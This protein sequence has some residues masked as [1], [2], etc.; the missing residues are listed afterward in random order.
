MH[1]ILVVPITCQSTPCQI[2]E[3]PV[4][5]LWMDT[6]ANAYLHT[7]FNCLSYDVYLTKLQLLDD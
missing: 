6:T 5:K 4:Y 7:M 1:Y 3:L 2:M